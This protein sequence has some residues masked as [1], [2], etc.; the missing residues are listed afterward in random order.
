MKN[1]KFI[2]MLLA[3]IMTMSTAS[4]L[5]TIPVLAEGEDATTEA[6]TEAKEGEEDAEEE[7]E[8]E[9]ATN[10][11][12]LSEDYTTKKYSS[13]DEKLA[14]ITMYAGCTGDDDIKE[15][16]ADQIGAAIINLSKLEE[17]LPAVLEEIT[18]EKAAVMDSISVAQ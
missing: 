5:F 15:V 1:I 17:T 16:V 3:L 4:S 2:A 12:G 18:A 14:T 6:S 13:N 8:A 11:T 10:T 9:E 7:E